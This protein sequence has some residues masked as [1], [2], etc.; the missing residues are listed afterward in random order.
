[1]AATEISNLVGGTDV[2][3]ADRRQLVFIQLAVQ[4]DSMPLQGRT[5]AARRVI[6]GL[7]AVQSHARTGRDTEVSL[8]RT[9]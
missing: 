4:I 6:L 3:H 2:D 5:E 8:R 9:R 1:M 7:V